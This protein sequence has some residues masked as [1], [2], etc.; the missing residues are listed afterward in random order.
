MRPA[1]IFRLASI[2][3]SAVAQSIVKKVPTAPRSTPESSPTINSRFVMGVIILLFLSAVLA[4]PQTAITGLGGSTLNMVDRDGDGYGVGPPVIINTTVASTIT[5]GATS[6]TPVSMVAGTTTGTTL[7]NTATV[8]V[9]SNGTV[10]RTGGAAT[11]TQ[12]GAY[13]QAVSTYIVI[14]GAG[15]PT[16]A[17][18]TDACTVAS[19]TTGNQLLLCTT[20][21]C[22]GSY[23]PVTGATATWATSYIELTSVAAVQSGEVLASSPA[24][25]LGTVQMIEPFKT[26][27]QPN[28]ILVSPQPL[29]PYTSGTITFSIGVG[30]TLR[31]FQQDGSGNLL[32]PGSTEYVQVASVTSTSFTT[33]YPFAF[34]HNTSNGTIHLTDLRSLG[35]DADD[36]DATVHTGQQLIA[37]YTSGATFPATNAAVLAA[38]KALYTPARGYTTVTNVD[39]GPYNPAHIWYIAPG[40]ATAACIANNGSSTGCVGND[41]TGAVNNPGL[42]FL[43]CAALVSHLVV[44]DMVLGRDGFTDQCN[45]PSGSSGS[46]VI[47][48]SYPGEMVA[49]DASSVTAGIFF[50]AQHDIVV[51][52]VRF[53]N[54]GQLSGGGTNL[55]ATTQSFHD[56]I[57]RHVDAGTGVTGGEACWVAQWSGFANLIIEDNSCHN[58][59]EH[60]MYLGT[61]Y[62]PA[63]GLRVWR[64]VFFDNGWTALHLNGLVTG[65]LVQQNLSY[66]TTV[67]SFDIQSGVNNST[68]SSNIAVATDPLNDTIAIAIDNYKDQSDCDGTSSSLGDL[69]C[70]VNAATWSAGTATIGFSNVGTGV[71][72]CVGCYMYV[73][74]VTPSGYNCTNAQG[75][76]QGCIITAVDRT[77]PSNPLVSYA[78]A[79]NPGT[80]VST[81]TGRAGQGVGD[82]INNVI[83]NNTFISEQARSPVIYVV[84]Y[85]S[86]H[87]DTSK[88]PTIS[89]TPDTISAGSID[90]LTIRNNVLINNGASVQGSGDAAGVPHMAVAFANSN[91]AGSPYCC[92]NYLPTATIDHNLVFDMSDPTGANKW[93]IG[94]SEPTC[95][96]TSDQYSAYSVTGVSLVGTCSNLSFTTGSLTGNIWGDPKIVTSA[97]L[98]LSYVFPEAFDARLLN[99]SPAFHTGSTTNLPPYDALGRGYIGN[100]APSIGALERNL[101]TYG[102]NNLGVGL[103][104]ASI[105]PAGHTATCPING[106]PGNGSSCSSD[107]G[108][109]GG[110]CGGPTGRVNTSGTTITWVSGTLFDATMAGKVMTISGMSPS[111]TI[112]TF[113][114]TTHLVT[115]AS[116]T[117]LSNVGYDMSVYLG[118]S[119]VTSGA[120]YNF[121]NLCYAEMAAWSGG[122]LRDAPQNVALCWSGAGHADYGGNEVQ[123]I[124]VNRTTPTITRVFGPSTIGPRSPYQ[125]NGV[126]GNIQTADGNPNGRH[127]Y[128]QMTY[129]PPSSTVAPDTT[130]MYN[131]ALFGQAH[132]G[133]RW[134]F[135]HSS[136]TW[137]LLDPGNYPT[138]G[139]YPPTVQGQFD[140]DPNSGLVVGYTSAWT[141]IT[142]AGAIAFPT[143][144]A[145]LSWHNVSSTIDTLRRNAF[146]SGDY[147]FGPLIGSYVMSFN[148]IANV[149]TSVGTSTYFY[150][151]TSPGTGTLVNSSANGWAQSDAPG[152]TFNQTHDR[153]VVVPGPIVQPGGFPG[154]DVYLVNPDP[155][156]TLVSVKLTGIGTPPVVSSCG[157]TAGIQG[158][159]GRF[160]YS[161]VMDNYVY[162]PCYGTDAGVLSLQPS[163]PVGSCSLAPTSLGQWTIGQVISS[164]VTATNCA[165]STYTLMSG[166]FLPTG[167]SLNSSTGAI[168]GTISASGVF[169]P[170][171]NYD[172]ATNPL[173]ITV[174]VAATIMTNSPLPNGSQGVSYSQSLASSGGTG[175]I[176][177]ALTG[178]SFGASGLSLSMAGVISG[179]SPVA[180]TY[181]G[182][183][184]TPTD[185]NGV[186]GAS[187]TF[188]VTI[189]NPA[190]F[191]SSSASMGAVQNSGA[192][193]Q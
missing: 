82:S 136:N 7:N 162:V 112:A 170:T 143:G 109:T 189:S 190:P 138:V 117:T 87:G 2:C 51:D 19:I 22:P 104:N 142:P 165:G 16:V 175:A 28:G 128:Q 6:V 100:P 131:G 115:M 44:G 9:L 48:M 187:K 182:L 85:C 91:D 163:D 164:G 153:I 139:G 113:T 18:V 181:G 186:A 150:S 154:N 155:T 168:T 32:W 53:Q 169:S 21:P 184:I 60:G 99:T 31:V 144:S 20:G 1:F 119:P 176:T 166:T 161:Q 77:T 83:E 57:I 122:F 152:L 56:I 43:T 146:N 107:G 39:Y 141:T 116:M 88:C 69:A 86:A 173:N 55:Y 101:Y 192:V 183:V 47:F 124:D 74:G 157:G 73:F 46:P 17:T 140:W 71:D 41:S 3:G 132:Y 64:N 135:T 148:N 66:G 180:G 108:I 30:M 36:L 79:S 52:N 125:D 33:V 45:I 105:V 130:L 145:S 151:G 110:S 70:V 120:V 13:G 5:A 23:T 123:C 178:G 93:A 62:I 50:G 10:N 137:S 102:W 133:D 118:G 106:A 58:A 72:F 149:P 174:N 95:A 193:L 78:V 59:F 34:T 65:A 160:R 8:N 179:S 38:V 29:L 103:Y 4:W 188:S 114:D 54:N 25:I 42:P 177:Y 80:Y 11:F 159:Y 67:N 37:K 97:P 40:S 158:I 84:N 24:G 171:I 76:P 90:N 172:T 49:F 27:A 92:A 126:N 61:T 127:T 94:S 96:G 121:Q 35:P 26:M 129:I 167:L 147:N 156:G 81:T 134:R 12:S 111:P 63:P 75:H 68:F 14:P 89:G 98:M 15:C 191:V 185:A